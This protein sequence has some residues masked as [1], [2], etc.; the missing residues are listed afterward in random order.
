MLYRLAVSVAK[1][2]LLCFIGSR[3]GAVMLYR[4]AVSTSLVSMLC[5]VVVDGFVVA[6]RLAL[7]LSISAV[8]AAMAAD[9]RSV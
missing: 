1:M 4:L 6:S 2:A 9:L 5:F 7:L 8:R 3:D